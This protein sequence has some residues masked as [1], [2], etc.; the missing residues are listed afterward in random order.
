ML[1]VHG[2]SAAKAM[3][4]RSFILVTRSSQ[5]GWGG[6]GGVFV[7]IQFKVPFKIISAHYET[8]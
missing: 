7:F 6:G 5:G 3:L 2:Q 1:N 8:G 4:Q